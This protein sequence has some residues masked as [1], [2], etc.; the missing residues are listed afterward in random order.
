MAKIF[1]EYPDV[2][3]VEQVTE[4]LN[5]SLSFAYRIIKSGALKSKKFGGK[6]IITKENVIKF[7]NGED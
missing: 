5:I 2:V 1:D 4:M 3:T 7:L 6:Y